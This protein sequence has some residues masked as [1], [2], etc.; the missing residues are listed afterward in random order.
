MPYSPQEKKRALVRVRRI[1]GQLE[2]L[3]GALEQEA[4]CG[5]VLQQIAAIRGAVN[6]L[7]ADVLESHLRAVLDPPDGARPDGL[8]VEQTVALVRSYLK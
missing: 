4:D 6:G 5:A 8:H 1:G 3:A 7:M 2:S